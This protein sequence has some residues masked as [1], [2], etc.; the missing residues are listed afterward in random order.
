MKRKCWT[1]PINLEQILYFLRTTSL[2]LACDVCL[3]N[4]TDFFKGIVAPDSKFYIWMK[5]FFY[6]GD[7]YMNKKV[8]GSKAE[9]SLVSS[10][11]NLEYFILDPLC[12]H[13]T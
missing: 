6:V 3:R 5:A 8:Y 12:V 1:K 2:S 9:Y 11:I 7:F 4:S 13:D 10:E